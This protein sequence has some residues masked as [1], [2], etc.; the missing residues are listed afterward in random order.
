MNYTTTDNPSLATVFLL[1]LQATDSGDRYC[2][3]RRELFSHRMDTAP[4]GLVGYIVRVWPKS[5]HAHGGRPEMAPGGRAEGE[6]KEE[7]AQ[8]LLEEECK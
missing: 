8:A 1:P 5:Q 7:A 4:R 6:T 2:R 3:R